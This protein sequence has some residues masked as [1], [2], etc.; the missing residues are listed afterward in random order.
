MAGWRDGHPQVENAGGLWVDQ[1]VVVDKN[2]VTSR[3]PNDLPVF[4][5]TLIGLATATA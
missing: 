4:C 2:L 3:V 1:E 5:K